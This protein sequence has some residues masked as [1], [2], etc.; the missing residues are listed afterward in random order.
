MYVK[1]YIYN[2]VSNYAENYNFLKKN[3]NKKSLLVKKKWTAYKTQFWF[4]NAKKLHKNHGKTNVQEFFLFS[5]FQ[6]MP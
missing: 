2:M 3:D 1:V 4:R 5:F 6:L